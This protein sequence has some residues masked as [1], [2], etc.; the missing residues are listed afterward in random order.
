MFINKIKRELELIK[1]KLNRN[2]Q[3]FNLRRFIARILLSLL[4]LVS[5]IKNITGGYK[6][7]IKYAK[8]NKI[9]YAELNVIMGLIIK[10]L[11]VISLISGLLMEYII[12]LLIIYLIIVI[13]IFNNPLKQKDILWK[14]LSLLGVVGG[15]LLV[16]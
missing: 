8:L 1:Y 15:L 4:F 2:I 16:Y 11:G 5:I 9:P 7:S 12:P 6:N 13:I 10:T 14:F 3:I